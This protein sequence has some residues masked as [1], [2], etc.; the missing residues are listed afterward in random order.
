MGNPRV[1]IKIGES[2]GSE[3]GRDWLGWRLPEQSW[4][5]PLSSTLM[6]T[7]V[8]AKQAVRMGRAFAEGHGVIWFEEPVSSDDLNGLRE[9]RGLVPRRDAESTAIPSAISPRCGRQ[10]G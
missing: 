5:T 1:K 9:V 7:A 10:S 4:A 3:P 8:I 6:P 2:W